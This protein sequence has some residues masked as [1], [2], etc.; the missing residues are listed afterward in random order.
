MLLNA[1]SGDQKKREVADQ[2]RSF[3][4]ERGLELDV[5]LVNGNDIAAQARHARDAG[6]DTVIAGGG[7]GTI[8]AVASELIGSG[9]RMGVLP[10][11]TFNYFARQLGI[12]Q[13]V[14]EC[15]SVCS[16][17][18]G[19][20]ITLAQVN[21][22]V[23][24]NNASIGLY[25]QILWIREKTYRHWGRSRL[26]AYWAVVQAFARPRVNLRLTLTL[27]GEKHYVKTPMI[28]VARNSYQLREFELDGP[29][30]VD[31]DGFAVFVLPAVGRLGL[32]RLAWRMLRRRI[33]TP[34]DIKV[35]CGRE[36]EIHGARRRA[37]LALDGERFKLNLPLRFRVVPRALRMIVPAVKNGEAAA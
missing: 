31:A 14:P 15:F 30:C 17:P 2:L 20:D 16:Q 36:L 8:N 22:R 25:P 4:Q 21:G 35:L 11:G 12:P 28:F 3:A 26:A 9:V 33:E 10:L 29:A 1:G 7:D 23:F 19:Q 37:T 34:H 24:L 13:E 27:D 6:Y 5:H 32:L 18:D